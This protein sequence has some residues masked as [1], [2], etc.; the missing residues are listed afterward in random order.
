MATVI[1]I[2]S[3][4]FLPAKVGGQKGIA[5]FN[6][7]FSKQLPF[8]CVT[9]ERN[10][11][12]A[13]EG[14]EVLNILSNSTWRY[15]NVFN[16][17]LFQKLIKK[18]QASHIMLE[19]PYLGWLGVLLKWFC[20]VKLVVHSHNIEGLRWKTLG[21][22]WWKI[23]W[24][25]E[26]YTHRQADYNF[27]IHD[28]DRNYALQHFGLNPMKCITMTYGI[29]WEKIPT[30]E[31]IQSCRILIREK[32]QI[33]ENETTLLFN[34]AFNYGPNLDALK[35]IIQIIDPLLQK[36]KHFPYKIIICGKDIPKEIEEKKY[37]HIL[38]AGFV[39][40]ISIY[41]KGSDIFLNPITE[42]GG[43]KTKLVEA[44]AYN[45][46]AV[47]T[48]NGAIGI[49]KDWCNGKLLTCKDHHWEDFVRRIVQLRLYNADMPDSY[50]EHFY[51]GNSTSRAAKFITA[52]VK[53]Y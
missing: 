17:F 46:N 5:L 44:L 24:R 49:N 30:Q 10:D 8:I 28:D 2:V 11:P 41:F 45:L 42:G 19:H 4:N 26:K 6:K 36:E 14:Y 21:K 3:Y 38:I 31:E 50:F 40:D 18:H 7:Y 39:E 13:A 23:L 34:G 9:V 53:T 25:Y 51:W 37:S 33:S 16:F 43:I 27:F 15:I 32:Y 1:S 48:E 29:E 47:S 22:W 20:G 12:Q 52:K 35:N